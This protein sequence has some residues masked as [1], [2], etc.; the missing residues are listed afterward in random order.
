VL[1]HSPG[2][3]ERVLPL[4]T[5]FREQSVVPDKLR[6][7]AILSAVREKEAAYVWAAQVAAAKRAGL[8]ESTINVLRAKGDPGSLSAEEREIVVYVRELMRTNKASQGAFDTLQKKYGT[9]WLVELRR[10]RT[11]SRCSPASSTRSRW[12]RR[13]TATR[14]RL[15]ASAASRGCAR[16]SFP[17]PRA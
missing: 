5:F 13:R 6:S 1:L 14:C 12:R 16:G 3:A 15:R 7:V 9:Q 17:S 2:L 10:P 4:V 8:S 11:T